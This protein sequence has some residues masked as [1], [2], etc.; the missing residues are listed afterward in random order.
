M[1]LERTD[2]SSDAREKQNFDT[3]TDAML[4]AHSNDGPAVLSN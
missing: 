4:D 3:T 2:I 1:S